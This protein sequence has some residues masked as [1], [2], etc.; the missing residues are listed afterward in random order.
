M[1]FPTDVMS[2]GDFKIGDMVR[3]VIK[4]KFYGKVGKIVVTN[5][6]MVGVKF[7][8]EKEPIFFSFRSSLELV[9]PLWRIA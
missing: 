6:H 1:N 2:L 7:D 8:G 3:V 5:I 9:K 4:S